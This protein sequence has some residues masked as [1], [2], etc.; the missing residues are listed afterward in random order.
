MAGTRRQLTKLGSCR[1]CMS[2][3]FI[4]T[5]AGW[6]VFWAASATQVATGLLRDAM[7]P[8]LA[9]L[10]IGSVAHLVALTVRHVTQRILL[11]R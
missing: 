5:I 9:V 4:V 8:A 10:T 1:R 11:R 6:L 7:I 2:S 3:S